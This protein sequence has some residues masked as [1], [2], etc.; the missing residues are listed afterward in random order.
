M[1]SIEEHLERD[2][3]ELAR[4]A[5]QVL[6]ER[7]VFERYGPGG[8]AKCYQ[9]TLFHLDYLRAALETNDPEEFGQYRVWLQDLLRPRGIPVEHI[10]ANFQ[11]LSEVLLARYGD[12]AAPAIALL[13]RGS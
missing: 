9:D 10:D 4:Q 8:L 7:G 1:R 6:Q 12:A 2:A 11:A 13:T 5:V 3:D